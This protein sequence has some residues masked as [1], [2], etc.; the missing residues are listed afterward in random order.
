MRA[1]PI[2]V[3]Q[4]MAGSDNEIM[5]RKRRNDTIHRARGKFQVPAYLR[6]SHL[7]LGAEQLDDS[8]RL[9]N[10]AHHMTYFTH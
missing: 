10:H 5:R 7:I 9:V 4:N 3:L 6:N 1:G 2:A 8:Q